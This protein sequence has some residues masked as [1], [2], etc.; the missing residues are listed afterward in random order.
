VKRNRSL[1][2]QIGL[3]VPEVRLE[4]AQEDLEW[5]RGNDRTSS[6][7]WFDLVRE[8]MNEPRGGAGK[9]ERPRYFEFEVVEGCCP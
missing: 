2:V 7:K 5:P 6:L 3:H 1:S 9:P 8:I 4:N